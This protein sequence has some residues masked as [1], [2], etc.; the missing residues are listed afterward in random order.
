MSDRRLP[1]RVHLAKFRRS[2]FR[3]RFRGTK[4]TGKP[5]IVITS[6]MYGPTMA[7][8][9]ETFTMHRLWQASDRSAF[10]ANLS[11]RARGIATTGGFGADAALMDALPQAKIVASFSVG[12]DAVDLEAA[13]RR[14]VAV[15][16]TPDVLTDCVADLGMALTLAL[17]RRVCEADRFVRAGKWLK[18]NLDYGTKLGGK[19]MGIVGMGRIGQ[20]VATR[21]AAFGMSIVYHGPCAKPELP[22]R[23]YGDLAAMAEASH[24]LMLTSPGGAATRHLVNARILG[25]LGKKGCVVNVARGS[26]VDEAALVTALDN[27][28]IA[29]AGLD[30]FV[31]E[32][33]VP[34]ALLTMENVVLQ[35]HQAS[36]T[37]ET[38]AAMGQLVIDNL[39]AFFAGQPLL[40]RVV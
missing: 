38:R 19:T 18:G 25:A 27:G 22:Y 10:L 24:V 29:G 28:V 35:P 7:Q 31:D 23:F 32:P 6:P 16:N 15:T 26:V 34:N 40:T 11:G 4:L 20:A 12:L 36:A 5:D 2:A 39:K 9:D 33:R 17:A 14:G 3:H 21:A 1:H 37:H 8:L 30:V 13:R